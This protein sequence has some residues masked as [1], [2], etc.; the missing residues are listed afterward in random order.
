MS[1]PYYP[2]KNTSLMRRVLLIL[3]PLLALIR[4]YD[5]WL[6]GQQV[7]DLVAGLGLALMFVGTLLDERGET[8]ARQARCLR[9]S[10]TALWVGFVAFALSF[11]LRFGL[12]G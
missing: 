10:R 11:A 7:Y 12:F 5:Y 1:A 2:G 4:V 9:I 3:L 6:H 8:A